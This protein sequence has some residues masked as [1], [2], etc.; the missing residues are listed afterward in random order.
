MYRSIDVAA[1]DLYQVSVATSSF[2]SNLNFLS[3]SIA[4]EDK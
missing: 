3:W 1:G 4:I 2:S